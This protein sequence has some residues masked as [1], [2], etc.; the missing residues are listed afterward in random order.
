MTDNLASPERLAKWTAAFREYS[1]DADPS[2]SL[3][4]LTRTWRELSGSAGMIAVSVKNLERG[5][6]R[7]N[8]LLHKEVVAG[9]NT[10]DT[11]LHSPDAPIRSGGVIGD[12][13][14]SEDAKVLRDLHLTDDPVLGD[15]IAAYT[16]ILAFPI[17]EDGEITSWLLNLHTEQENVSG[18]E[19]ENRFIQATLVGNVTDE[20]RLLKE[21]KEARAWIEGEIDE[22]AQIQK[23]LLPAAMPTT[24]RIAWAPF[25]ETYARAGGDYYDVFPLNGQD[26]AVNRWGVLIADAA[27]HGPSAAVVIAMLSALR[28]SFPGTPERPSE[29]LE[30]LNLNLN[31]SSI[32]YSFVTAHLAFIDSDALTMSYACAGHP[33]PLLREP[34]ASVAPLPTECSFPLGV[35]LSTRYEDTEL[36]LSAGQTLLLYTDGITEA[37]SPS[38]DL[39]GEEELLK[40]FA[41]TKGSADER[42]AQLV[43]RLRDHEAGLQP[44]D[45]QTMLVVHVLG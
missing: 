8:R 9:E 41:A 29:M 5:Q 22:I 27:G 26:E 37:R 31:R 43:Q 2:T 10:A 28:R 30:Y 24:E 35:E 36:Q 21:L 6:Y 15:Q 11:P 42:L 1:R 16:Q 14:A 40:V 13:I 32:G 17:F 23:H 18:R 45:D 4:N 39:L 19:I 20:K 7:V 25:Y 3:R 44:T 38:R 12:I 33:A 34:D